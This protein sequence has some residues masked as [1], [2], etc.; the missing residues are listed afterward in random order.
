MVLQILYSLV[1]LV[2]LLLMICLRNFLWKVSI[3]VLSFLLRVQSS[4]LYKKI[5]AIRALKILSL[6]SRDISLLHSDFLFLLNAAHASCF[7]FAISSEFPS[8][9]PKYLHCLQSVSEFLLIVYSSVLSWLTIRFLLVRIV[10]IVCLISVMMVL[11][12]VTQEVSS[13]YCWSI[14]KAF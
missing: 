3:L 11:F 5:G 12:V 6:T 7:L 1:F 8:K 4:E 10:G 14:V 9:L 2:F 13:A